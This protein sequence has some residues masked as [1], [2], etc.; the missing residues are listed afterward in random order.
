ML[1][2]TDDQRWDTLWAMPILQ[3]KLAK[4]GVT[5]KNAFATTPLCCPARASLLSGGFYPQNTGVLTNGLPNGG[6]KRFVD[7]ETLG[8]L[9]H[10]RVFHT[11]PEVEAKDPSYSS[12]MPSFRPYPNL[13]WYDRNQK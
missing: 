12:N 5:F 3:E 9:L 10:R 8:T 11:N 7:S 4:R 1:F 13:D 6:M 2:L